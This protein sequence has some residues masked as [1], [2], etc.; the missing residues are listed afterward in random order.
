MRGVSWGVTGV[1]ALVFVV[2]FSVPRMTGQSKNPSGGE[3]T[4]GKTKSGKTL[5]PS[6]QTSDR[7]LA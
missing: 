3:P 4:G 7:C 2:G 1:L 5:K 6:F